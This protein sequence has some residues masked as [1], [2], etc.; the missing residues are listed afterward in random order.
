MPGDYCFP[1]RL[2]SAEVLQRRDP[3]ETT[4][5]LELITTWATCC[6]SFQ[7]EKAI[8]YWAR[9][10]AID[11]RLFAMVHRNLGWAASTGCETD[12]GEAIGRYEKAMTRNESDPRLFSMSWT[13]CTNWANVSPADPGWTCWRPITS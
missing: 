13:A 4:P 12:V 3:G 9:S 8:D 6:S 10:A 5:M 1:F 7:P 11:D 2:E